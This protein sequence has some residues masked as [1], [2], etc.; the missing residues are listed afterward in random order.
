M[1]AT[2]L[3]RTLLALQSTF[4]TGFEFGPEGLLVDVRP[5]WRVYSGPPG[6]SVRRTWAPGP[7][8]LGSGSGATSF[9]IGAGV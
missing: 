7:A 4:V 1:R 2:S 6:H 3:L 8:H 9:M 5:T